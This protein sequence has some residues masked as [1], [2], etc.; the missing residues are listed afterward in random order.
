[1]R[2]DSAITPACI[3]YRCEATLWPRSAAVA[4]LG[5]RVVSK[6]VC[7]RTSLPYHAAAVSSTASKPRMTSSFA[8]GFLTGASR[9]RLTCTSEIFSFVSPSFI[10]LNWN[11]FE[12][13]FNNVI[14]Q[15][16]IRFLGGRISERYR[17]VIF[18]RWLEQYV[19]SIARRFSNWSSLANDV[20]RQSHASDAWFPRMK[21]N[22]AFRNS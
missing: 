14:K 12:Q 3:I 18:I 16:T 11:R 10:S 6:C 4:A 22:V 15:C 19:F 2:R 7:T 21:F 9:F 17:R 1:M 13:A 20:E 5:R 8:R